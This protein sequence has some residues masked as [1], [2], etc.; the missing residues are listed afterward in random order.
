MASRTRSWD[1]IGL[2]RRRMIPIV[3]AAAI[4]PALC[5]IVV[6][7]PLVGQVAP[8]LGVVVG[9]A[10][11]YAVAAL[12]KRSLERS[13]LLQAKEAPTLAASGA[14]YLQGTG[15]K[16]KT[17]LMLHSDEPM[18]HSVLEDMKRETLLGIDARESLRRSEG[19][20]QSQSV[21]RI[22]RSIVRAHGERLQ[23]GG[24][25]LESVVRS[26]VSGEETKFPV[27]MTI[28]FFLPIML[29]IFAAMEHHSDLVSIASLA[30]LELVVLDLALSI[31]STERRRLAA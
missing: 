30:F 28:A 22:L 6:A 19:R 5:V 21:L 2:D 12:P 1:V 27:F 18:L 16:S 26:S 25:E 8:V 14:V 23:D 17:V 7:L 4:V 10:S 11:G 24:E 13:S 15:S 29:M 9:A 31:S 20:V 3:A